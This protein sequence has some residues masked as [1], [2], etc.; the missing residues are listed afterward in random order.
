MM[1][2]QGMPLMAVPPLEETNRRR[3]QKTK[4]RC[5]KLTSMEVL[6]TYEWYDKELPYIF[7]EGDSLWRDGRQC[8]RSFVRHAR[9]AQRLY[10][11]SISEVAYGLKT[12][13]REKFLATPKMIAGFEEQWRY[14]ENTQGALLYNN[15]QQAGAPKELAPN[16][17]SQSFF[18]TSEIAAG[19]ISK[20]LGMIDP[21]N[22][23]LINGASGAAIGRTIAEQNLSVVN[24]EQ[25]LYNAI[26]AC[27]R[28][29]MNLIP[30]LY[31]TER[32]V[33]IE[34]PDGKLKRVSI[35][36]FDEHGQAQNHIDELMEDIYDIEVSANMS[37]S[38]QDQLE[39]MFLM[40][41]MQNPQTMPLVADQVPK[42]LRMAIAPQLEQR[43]KYL[44]PEY[45]QHDQ[46]ARPAPPNPEVQ[47]EQ[48]KL[49]QKAQENQMKM[50]QTQ[51]KMRGDMMKDQTKYQSDLLRAHVDQTQMMGDLAKA[52]LENATELEA[53]H[54]NARAE[55]TKA[56]A[57]LHTAVKEA[58][59][60]D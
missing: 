11:Y 47:L 37:D 59:D 20:T 32:I 29:I 7:V 45:V 15:D 48:Q 40:N 36:G 1:E 8:I 33:S 23:G 4:I 53:A 19:D 38:A 35:N 54:I 57:D 18:N 39:T 34:T 30:K 52:E 14:P 51:M 13:R 60:N 2:E 42:H 56:Y 9:D 22:G 43:L 41:L 31:D 12:S 16:E 21:V 26:E 25:N 3:T 55:M 50:V 5:Y 24:Y 10:N 58:K 49:H 17:V 44:V 6:E 46:P 27:G 28:M